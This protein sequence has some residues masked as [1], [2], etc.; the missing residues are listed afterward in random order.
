ME[1]TTKKTKQHTVYRLSDG[2]RV[3]GT[4]TILGI[5]DKPALKYWANK[6][7]LNGIEIRSYVDEK[8]DIG[9]CAHYRI[10]C[11]VK[12]IDPD[13]SIY[14]PWTVQQSDNC[15][16]KW[17]EWCKGKETSF[18]GSEMVLVSETHKFGGTIDIYARINGEL[19]LLDIKTSG[20]GIYPEMKH[21]T[22]GA[23]RLLLEENGYPVEKVKILRIGRTEEE[24]FEEATIGNWGAHT[25]VALL[26]RQ[27]YDALK[28]AK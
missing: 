13:L 16:L 5:L 1:Q 15:M 9:T 4:T 22:A 3:P 20:S 11:E 28:E 27:L 10:E 7:G 8:A 24:G 19:T 12:G 17:W 18:I 14:S 25:D 2:K 21:Q 23:Y 26:C 6:I